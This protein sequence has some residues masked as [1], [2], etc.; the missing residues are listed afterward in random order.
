MQ[1][2]SGR[3]NWENTS[4]PIY[5]FNQ[6]PLYFY[7][8]AAAGSAFGYSEVPLHLFQSLFS[9]LSIIYFYKLLCLFHRNFALLGT[10][11]LALGPAFIVNQNLMVDVPVLSVSI[12]F[13]YLL[14]KYDEV[15]LKRDIYFAALILSIGLLFK[16]SLLPLFPIL[17]Y[18]VWQKK[19]LDLTPAILVP[20]LF[21]MAWTTLN[22]LE[23]GS[24]HMGGRHRNEISSKLLFD[25]SIAFLLTLG[26]VVPF[27]IVFIQSWFK[28]RRRQAIVVSC[29]CLLI[30]VS[31]YVH[32][33]GFQ[34][35][36]F[37]HTIFWLAFLA[38]GLVLIVLSFV[39]ALEALLLPKA[40]IVALWGISMAVFITL[41]AP[42]MATRHILL[43][44]PPLI[45]LCGYL[46]DHASRATATI[47]LILTC[48]LGLT[49]G[50]SDWLYADFYRRASKD[51][52]VSVPQGKKVWAVGHWG[53]QWYSKQEN[54]HFYEYKI[55]NLEAGDFLISP[56]VYPKQ[57]IPNDIELAKV[58]SIVYSPSIWNALT[59]AHFARFYNS[60]ST[61]LP[62]Y[63][64]N[65]P[66]DSVTVYKV[67]RTSCR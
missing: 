58:A 27:S 21:L 45:I 13:I 3:V 26:A 11:F 12:I 48:F 63:L 32:V 60:Y 8:I 28:A 64:S 44:L 56:E 42:F 1:P 17:V 62:W 33:Y 34:I 15:H 37:P 20:L 24:S 66:V 54:M 22:Y 57:Q 5:Y 23:F 18:S 9:L 49:L 2:M 51:A 19:R 40:R 29:F 46:L 30:V 14:I 65:A 47:S 35:R 4:Q 67:V 61:K 59:T 53:W 52:L 16:Y 7:F 10:S 31:A 41:Y 6:P 36:S 55:S 50:V 38:N 43:I 25:N 39:G